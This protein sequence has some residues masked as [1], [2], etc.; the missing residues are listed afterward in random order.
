M[1]PPDRTTIKG[2]T[3]TF[4]VHLAAKPGETE[5]RMVTTGDKVHAGDR[6][7]FRV[8]A[9]HDGWLLVLGKDDQGAP[10]VAYPQATG[11][12]AK[13]V[14]TDGLVTLPEA[15]EFDDVLGNERLVA[16]FCPEPFTSEAA[17]QA[18]A[19][20]ALSNAAL[21]NAAAVAGFQDGCTLRD[22]KLVKQPRP[23]MAR[24]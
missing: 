9:K 16:F 7:G 1:E 6:A 2:G 18:L 23:P 12:P 11:K 20:D 13:Q 4:Q 17:S 8:Q 3:L 24:E 19:E 14:A 15:I 5:T 22:V 10:Y 21:S